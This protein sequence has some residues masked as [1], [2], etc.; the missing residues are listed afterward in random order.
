MNQSVYLTRCSA[1]LPNA[2]VANDQIE[3]LLGQVGERPSRAR[4]MV[5]RNNGIEQRHYAIDPLTG[6]ASHSNAQ[7]TAEAVRG[8][9]GKGFELCD[10][11]LLACGTS[12]PDQLAPNHAVMVHGELASPPCEAM[13]ASGICVAGVMSFKYAFMSIA[14]RLTRNA[15]A[16]GSEQVSSFMRAQHFA[17]ESEERVKALGKR[18]GLGF[19]KDFLRWMLSDGAGAVL[20]EDRPAE[21]GLSLRVEWVDQFSYAGQLEPCMYAGAEKT[22][23]GRLIG[24]REFDSMQAVADRSVMS[25]KQDVRLLEEGIRISARKGFDDMLARRRL[26]SDEVDHLLPHYSSAHFRPVMWEVMPPDWKIPY[27]RWFT[28][29]ETRGNVGSASMYLM[30]HDLL[31]SGRVCSGERILCFVPES[32]R[33]STA[34]VYLTVV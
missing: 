15:V 30:L 19:E 17:A 4:A 12:S 21:S 29:L 31:A 1:F 20:L 6:R 27:E 26:R 9:C 14:A 34:F 10:M 28:N 13:A 7:L 18:P 32:G 33:F 16:T 5:L 23:D 8:L 11:Q 25:V 24:W 3:G 2:P 22:P